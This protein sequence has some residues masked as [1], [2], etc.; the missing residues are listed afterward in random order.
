AA[1]R[2]P[3]G[4]LAGLPG[5]VIIDE[6]QRVPELFPA[7]KVQVDND[8]V[9]GRFLL[10]GSA[11]VLM[12]PRLSESLAGRMEI[13]TLWPLAQVEIEDLSGGLIDALFDPPW[14]AGSALRIGREDIANRIVAGGYPEPLQ[15][16][17]EA[18][19]SAWFGSY[20]TT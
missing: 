5:P 17:G 12:L 18:R 2:D 13:L 19:R 7:I 20:L 10:T 6:V 8:R 15:R 1:R 16:A 3:A 9:A 14:T 11:S 4:F